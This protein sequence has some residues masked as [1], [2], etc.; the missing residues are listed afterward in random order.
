[1][2]VRGSRVE[3][4]G[5]I[6]IAWLVVASLGGLAAPLD[7]QKRGGKAPAAASGLNITAVQTQV[8]LDRAGFSPGEIDGAIGT[9][10]TRALDAFT[11]NGGKADA[12]P[13][14]AV[15]AYRITDE[16]AAGPFT[17]D[18]PEDMVA[19]SKLPAL[20]Y[21]SLLEALGERFHASPALLR[22][23]NPGAKF[24]AGEEIQVPNVAAAVPPVG[25]PRGRQSDA[26]PGADNPAATVVTVKK[27]TSDLTVVDGTGKIL[28][29]A[30]VT[31][32]S[33]HDP[34]PIG[35]WKVTGVQRDPKFHYN[36]DLFWDADPGHS[37]AT[38]PPGPNNPV[39]VVWVDISKPHYGMHGTPEPATVGKTAS[40]GC[41]RL[42]NWDAAKLASLVRPGTR[43]V[44]SE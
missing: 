39:G 31:T 10:T 28:M 20:G 15:T 29:Y 8:M 2:R 22:R 3:D 1:M 12:L 33:E 4:R 41:V 43:V 11:R 21:A 38:I 18:I 37:K 14:D 44:F 26:A 30:P 34:L 35:E 7:A 40:H 16:D 25:P 27:S 42:T 24:A 13:A 6:L 17:P 36:P 32:G 19:K 5:S 23:M 9:S